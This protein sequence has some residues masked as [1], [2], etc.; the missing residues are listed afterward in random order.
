M[1]NIM[2][3][4]FIIDDDIATCNLLKTIT[5]PIF[6]QVLTYESGRDFLQESIQETDI[7]ILDLMMP[8]FDG[9]EVIRHLAQQ[10]LF[11][12]LILISGY[13]QGVLYSAERLAHDYGL[14][15]IDSFT[16]PI[17]ISG[18][19]SVLEQILD[20]Q[21]STFSC[22]N[23][24]NKKVTPLEDTSNTAT[25]A[26]FIPNI[27]DIEIG[28]E[29]NQFI[30]HFQPQISIKTHELL[31]VEA[32]VRWQ[33]PIHGLI[34]PDLFIPLAEQSAL[35]EPLTR[36][37]LELA[38]QQSSQWGNQ[39]LQIKISV[40]LSAQNINSLQLP[41]Q[42]R[43]LVRSNHLDPSMIMLEVTESALM[44]NLTTSLDIL[45][46]LRLKGFQLSIDDFGTGFSSLSQLHKIPFTELKIDQSF[47]GKIIEDPE[48]LAIVETCVMLGHKLNMTVVAE[49]IENEQVL[50]KLAEINCDIAQ[51]YYFAKPMPAK[52]LMTW[53]Q[54]YSTAL[55]KEGT[56]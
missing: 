54:N 21:S 48:S 41:E 26:K 49:G 16:K 10:Q 7:A 14:T 53:H 20:K 44:G 38:V 3:R 28:I 40:N 39:G 4:L 18:L 31:G 29:E 35:I 1:V 5:E 9:I 46:R 27:Q 12:R 13:D 2:G 43:F 24:A 56:L 15:V 30:L 42:L 23:Q 34:F 11:P 52:D 51:G 22:I 32:L 8:D 47:V 6:T 55:I 36:E 17:S 50:T 25:V 45:T 33:H 19:V 37:I